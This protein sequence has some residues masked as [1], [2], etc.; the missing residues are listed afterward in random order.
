MNIT[1]KLQLELGNYQQAFDARLKQLDKQNFAQ[2]LW[3][4]DESLWIKE[5]LQKQISEISLGWLNVVDKMFEVL[6]VIEEFCE[7][8]PISGFKHI[9]LLGMGGSSLAPLVFKETF[10]N[11]N[12]DVNLI[13][14]DS[15]EPQTIKKIENEINI[16]K[17]LFIVSSKSGN[18]AE[19]MAFY[20]YFY[21]RVY[22]IK[23]DRTGENF[24]AI[25]D[26]DS[27]L[28]GLAKRKQFRKTFIN[29]PEIGGR[30]SALSYFGILPA[31]L[32]GVNV[33][34]LLTRTKVM[35]TNCGSNVSVYENP[36]IIL[37]TAIAEL[38]LQGCDKL[39]YLM[40]EKLNSFGLW[41]EQ[42]LAEST[43]KS[44][45]G[46]LPVNG[47]PLI[48]MET[49]SKDRYFVSMD[50]SESDAM[51]SEKLKHFSAKGYPVINISIDSLLDLGQ[52]FF[53]WEIATATAGA[54]LEVN[55]F[56]Q[57]NVQES[58]LCTNKLLKKVELNGCL[59]EMEPIV[60]ENL[61]H[62]YAVQKDKQSPQLDG[63]ILLED[64]F[65]LIKTGDY[66]ALQAYLPEET[67]VENS[68]LQIQL[69]LQKSLLLPVTTQFGPRYLHSTG[70]YHK[71]G[72]NTGFF[73][74]FICNSIE[75]IQI[76]GQPYTFGLLKRAQAI[77][78][79]QALIDH[80][81]KVILIDIGKDYISGLNHFNQVIQKMQPIKKIVKKHDDKVWERIYV[82]NTNLLN[83]Y[84][85]Y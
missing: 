66:I 24:I 74:Q 33:R 59:P 67:E 54:I 22:K 45:K 36:G 1:G 68:L 29:F 31:A 80:D 85:S 61:L 78:D 62:Y 71:G 23:E 69:N 53:R 63:K 26:K 12:P 84:Y 72:P 57:P 81:R 2:R 27:P 75:S 41:L 34:E 50:H 39:T 28:A 25:T 17:T 16:V 73:I 55:P 83:N 5:G 56:D 6:P 64:F 7:S 49:Y 42:L 15:T 60:I 38:A 51:T 52:E 14:L 79:M 48:E 3:N 11:A 37:G 77:G 44:N 21:D 43:G 10:Q 30:Y 65:A 46:I 82:N 32:M 8:K 9:V 4:K 20:D 35:V 18:T 58:K 47:N 13:V 76:P 19:V 70:Q 40:P